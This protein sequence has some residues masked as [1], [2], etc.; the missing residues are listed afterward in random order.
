MSWGP[1][2]HWWAFLGLEGEALNPASSAVVLSSPKYCVQMVSG[3][4]VYGILRAPRAASTGPW[5]SP[6]PVA[7]T[8]PTAR[9]WDDAGSCCPLP[10]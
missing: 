3:I 7:L 8:Q 6:C 5:C 9:L 10:G 4:N 1:G 2:S